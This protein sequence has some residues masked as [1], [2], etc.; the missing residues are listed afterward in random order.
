MEG[1][2]PY[3]TPLTKP[4]RRP[5]DFIVYGPSVSGRIGGR[6]SCWLWD[7][8]S[9]WAEDGT[10]LAAPDQ[11]RGAYWAELRGAY[12]AELPD[13]YELHGGEEG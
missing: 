12:W 2:R 5:G 9:W 13:A 11:M 3:W 4:P 10:E 6:Y 7:G 8:T 1:N